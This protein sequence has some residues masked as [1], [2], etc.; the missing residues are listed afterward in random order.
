MYFSVADVGKAMGLESFM[1][2][3][4]SDAIVPGFR[5]ETKDDL[6]L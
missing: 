3:I 5:T 4:S 1:C 6:I 2:V